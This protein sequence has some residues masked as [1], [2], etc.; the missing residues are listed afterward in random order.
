LHD[1][2]LYTL[3][4]IADMSLSSLQSVLGAPAKLLHCWAQGLDGSPVL[5]PVQRPRVEV[6]LELEPDDIDSTLSGRLYELLEQL[7]R[8]L[9]RQRQLCHRLTLL[10]QHSDHVHAS[11]SFRFP[12]STH[13]E[14]DMYPCLK[15]LFVRCFTRRVRLRTVTISA[16]VVDAESAPGEQLSLFDEHSAPHTQPNRDHR[17]AAVLDGMRERFGDRSMRWGQVDPSKKRPARSSGPSGVPSGGRQ[18]HGALSVSSNGSR[19]TLISP[20][21]CPSSKP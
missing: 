14:T 6:S 17:L 7:C 8:Q 3:G 21:N 9:R 12:S 19:S 1:F 11:K 16:D 10:L 13:W 2:N 18:R 4:Q 20:V 15:E 5:P